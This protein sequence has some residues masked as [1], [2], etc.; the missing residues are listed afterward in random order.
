[1]ALVTYTPP[2]DGTEIRAK[3]IRDLWTAL[4]AQINGN[5]DGNNFANGSISYNKLSIANGDISAL[6]ITDNTIDSDKYVDG[7]IDPEH[8]MAGTGTTWVWQSWSPTLAN[9]TIGNGTIDAKYIQIGKTVYFRFTLVLGTTTAMGSIPTFTLPITSAAY[10]GSTNATP[11]GVLNSYDNGTN[12]YS[13]VVIRN[14]TTV[15]LMRTH[16]VSGSNV[17]QANITATV[18][19]TWGST[20]E[21]SAWGAYEAA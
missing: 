17:I 1:M 10:T 12:N 16:Q 20:D 3:H 11:I 21:I 14:S 19:F 15:A 9:I 6:K 7:S 13:G 18:P 4:S 2:S 8:L 5:L